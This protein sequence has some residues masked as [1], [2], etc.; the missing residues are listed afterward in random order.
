MPGYTLKTNTNHSRRE[1]IPGRPP[2]GHAWAAG[3]WF[4]VYFVPAWQIM[5]VVSQ[6]ITD[7]SPGIRRETSFKEDT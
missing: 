2:E 1:W 3:W 6:N 5:K 7:Q 4:L